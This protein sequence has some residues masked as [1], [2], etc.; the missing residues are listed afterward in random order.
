MIDAMIKTSFSNE[1]LQEAMT[2]SGAEK[3]FEAY[4]EK[5]GSA[6]K[7]SFLSQW[8]SLIG[9]MIDGFSNNMGVSIAE[10]KYKRKNPF[11]DPRD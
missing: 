9:R 6:S 11:W 3:A 10:E 4:K 1:E 5:G 8:K 2:D 7:E